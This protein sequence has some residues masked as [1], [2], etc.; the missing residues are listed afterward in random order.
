M[1]AINIAISVFK[2]IPAIIE[3][4]KAIEE[5]IPGN[6][7]GEQKLAA[8]RGIL[9]SSYTQANELWPSVEKSIKVIVDLFNAVGV[10]KK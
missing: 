2:L 1:N 9:E 6:G 5:A 3:A 7:K 8:I 4:M 10:F